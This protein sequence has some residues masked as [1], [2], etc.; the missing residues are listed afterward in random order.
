MGSEMCIRDSN[1][2]Q[3][4]IMAAFLTGKLAREK[5]GLLERHGW[6]K[7]VGNCGKEGKDS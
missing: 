3:Q 7:E 2:T 1:N 5:N 4:N 6:E